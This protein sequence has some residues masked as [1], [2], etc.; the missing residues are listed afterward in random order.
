MAKGL[1]GMGDLFKQAQEMQSR[2]AQVQQELGRRSVEASSGG[3]MV[4]VSVN[5][6][7]T[8][9]SI[10][11]DPAAVNPQETEMLEDLILAAVNEGLRKAREMVSEE[12]SKVTGGLKI[13]GLMP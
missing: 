7:L 10:K 5:G 1:G 2:M 9:S 4:R 8:L 6:Q 3:G 13:P 11:V 12:M